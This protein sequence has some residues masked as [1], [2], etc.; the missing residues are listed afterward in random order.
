MQHT[1]RATRIAVSVLL[2]VAAATPPVRAQCGGVPTGTVIAFMGE[3]TPPGWM[4]ADGRPLQA[5]QYP[6]LFSALGTVHG[7]GLSTGATPVGQFN[8]PDLRGQF[9][10]GVDMSEAGD[11]SGKDPDADRRT[12]PRNGTGNSGNKVGSIQEDATRRPNTDFRTSSNG[13]HVHRHNLETTASR[14]HSGGPTISNTVAYP[15]VGSRNTNTAENGNHT[16][17]VIAGGDLET[18]PKNVAV[19]WLICAQ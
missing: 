2:A 18:R 12:A 3:S 4:V 9:L 6:A 14:V 11:E 16:H 10:R 13:N 15:F 8:L 17:S 19:R 1:V 5:A 7:A